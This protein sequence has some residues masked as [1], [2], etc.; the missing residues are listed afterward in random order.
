[1]LRSSSPWLL[2]LSALVVAL[3]VTTQTAR[4]E[5]SSQEFALR[6]SLEAKA[7]S[8]LAKGNEKYDREDYQGAIAN[9][10]KAIELVPYLAS[11]YYN[12]SLIKSTLQDR[13][14]AILDLSWTITV[15]PNHFYAY[16]DRAL[17]EYG[18][19]NRQEALQDLDRAI[20]LRPDWAEAYIHRSQVKR[21]L[22]NRQAAIDD[23]RQAEQLF[24]QAGDTD[25]DRKVSKL[26]G[27]LDRNARLINPPQPMVVEF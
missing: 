23:L 17:L 2:L 5:E 20:A 27:D 8:Y 19:G 18:L 3:P 26:L 16:Y 25:A 4:S 13:Q 24:R 12:R 1:M 15:K 11:A 9:Y 14:G 6:A 7:N 22:G 10:N 21:D